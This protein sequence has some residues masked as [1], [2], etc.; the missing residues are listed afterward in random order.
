MNPVQLTDNGCYILYDA[1]AVGQVDAQWFSPE[2]WRSQ[3]AIT[4]QAQGRGTTWFM[5]HQD[6]EFA[7]RHYRRGGSLARL[8]GNRYLWTGLEAS[9]AFR[10]WR[11]LAQLHGEGQPVPA[12]VAVR[13]CRR[14]LFYTAQLITARLAEVQSLAVALQRQRLSSEIWQHIGQ[15]LKRL[16]QHGV[17]HADLNAHNILLDKAGKVYVID[18]DRGEIRVPG[19]WQQSNLQRLKHSLNKLAQ[20]H[21]PFYFTELDFATLREAYH[22]ARSV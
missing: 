7:L 6:R 17:C 16:H 8:L 13:V 14:G 22:G 20:Q 2:F 15:T 4:G 1:D 21:S 9:R 19:R 3:Q 5:R 18:F 11:L 12:P 10:E